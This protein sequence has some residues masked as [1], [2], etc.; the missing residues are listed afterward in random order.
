MLLVIFFLFFHTV[1]TC[2]LLLIDRFDEASNSMGVICIRKDPF[3]KIQG[4]F[5]MYKLDTNLVSS[6][7]VPIITSGLPVIQPPFEQA[8][9]YKSAHSTW[10]HTGPTLRE[11]PLAPF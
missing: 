9:L 10:G 11:A 3:G 4:W 6:G 5:V 7:R 2:Q 8:N 1:Q